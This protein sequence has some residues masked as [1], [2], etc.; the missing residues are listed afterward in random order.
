M[1]FNLFKSKPTLK[2]IISDGFVDIH[3]HILP[4]IDD[5]A[6]NIKESLEI[7]EKLKTIGFKKIICTPHIY[8]NLYENDKNSIKESYDLLKLN[9]SNKNIQIEYGS[10][11]FIDNYLIELAE[12]KELITIKNKYVLLETS[13]TAMPMNINEIIFKICSN[14]YTPILA[15]PE[16]YLYMF[17]N[18]KILTHLKKIGCLFQLN[19]MSTIGYYGVDVI[20]ASDK[21][22]NENLIDFVGSDIHNINH[23]DKFDDR[24]KIKNEKKLILAIECNSYFSSSSTIDE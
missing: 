16:R 20:K 23:I 11:Y 9:H 1:I 10:E 15:H 13:F 8:P 7:I 14:G 19:L 4:G 24:I 2:E 12:K 3:S 18:F 21:L 22:L 5:G 6:Q 17:N